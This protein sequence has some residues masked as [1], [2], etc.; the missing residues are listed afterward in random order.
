MPRPV[1]DL[2]QQSQ[3]GQAYPVG[4]DSWLQG[5]SKKRK[6]AK[7]AQTE[8]WFQR[9]LPCQ[10][11]FPLVHGDSPNPSSQ[12][13]P[14]AVLRH[15]G[16]VQGCLQLFIIPKLHFSQ[17]G[18]LISLSCTFHHLWF[19]SGLLPLG[20]PLFKIRLK[21]TSCIEV[22]LSCLPQMISY[23][24]EATPS[25]P[26]INQL[27]CLSPIIIF[28]CHSHLLWLLN[29]ALSMYFLCIYKFLEGKDF[30]ILSSHISGINNNTQQMSL[31]DLVHLL[32]QTQRLPILC[33][34]S[35]SQSKNQ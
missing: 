14:G 13:L 27:F 16:Y 33:L 32:Y 17:T 8:R 29:S 34:P 25:I 9:W 11:K 30:V 7:M 22:L 20:M 19:C 10:S 28:K 18:L 3:E 1:S 35:K 21:S 2:D 4:T 26:F 31:F 23:L 12:G 24:S 5:K 15:T 6:E